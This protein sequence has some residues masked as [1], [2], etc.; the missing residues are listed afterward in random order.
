M[1]KPKGKRKANGPTMNSS[2]AYGIYPS[3]LVQGE[4]ENLTSRI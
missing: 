4:G 1:N 2:D 3:N